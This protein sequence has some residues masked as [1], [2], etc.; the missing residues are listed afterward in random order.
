MNERYPVRKKLIFQ[1]EVGNVEFFV[2]HSFER[3]DGG[4]SHVL[5][6]PC[7]EAWGNDCVLDYDPEH[8]EYWLNDVR[9]YRGSISEVGPDV[10]TEMH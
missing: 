5:K 9:Y 8:E 7:D 2:V 1:M 10:F 3:P 6:L 4:I